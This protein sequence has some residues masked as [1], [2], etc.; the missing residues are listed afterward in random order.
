MF[1]V[2]SPILLNR[3]VRLYELL[4]LPHFSTFFALGFS[5][6][7]VFLERKKLHAQEDIFI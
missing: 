2:I 3:A 6:G 5:R 1:T 7:N 4:L